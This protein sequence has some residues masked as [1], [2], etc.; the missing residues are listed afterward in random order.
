MLR[1]LDKE[2]G[3]ALGGVLVFFPGLA[4]SRVTDSLGVV[5]LP[6]GIRDSVRVITTHVGYSAVD[7]VVTA[8]A[9]GTTLDL[10]L[11]RSAIALAPLTVKAERAG[12]NSRELA[13]QMFEREVAIGA[14]G[15][16]RAEVQAVPA[17]AETDVFR[18][19]RSVPGVT[20][21]NDFGA[22]MFVRGGDADQVAVLLDGAP[23]FGPYHMFGVFGVFNSDAI[24]STE[25]YKGSIPARY[26]GSLSGVVSARQGT[27]V[28]GGMSF[29]G[30]LSVLGLRGAMNGA[31][32]WAHGRWLVAGRKATVD[33]AQLSVPFS[34]HDV[35]AAV[36][37]YPSE[38]HRLGISLLASN[39]D[40]S[41]DFLGFGKS[42]SS[43][44]ANLVS[45][46]TWSWVRGNR[47]S[48]DVSAYFSR[49]EGNLATGQEPSALITTNRIRA[50]GVRAQI[51][52]RGDVTGIRSGLVLEGGPVSLLGTG[53]G[54]YM[55]G[56]G[57]G[58]FLHAS[59]F[60]E[61]EHWIGALRL[62]PGIRAGT[63]RS[64][65]PRDDQF[66]IL[67]DV[68]GRLPY[69]GRADFSAR[70]AFRWGDWAIVPFLSV[71]NITGRANV[72]T[73]RPV[74]H[75]TRKGDYLVAERQLPLFPFVG[76]DFRFCTMHSTTGFSRFVLVV[77]TI[78]ASACDIVV[79]TVPPG[80]D[81]RLVVVAAL[82]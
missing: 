74:T 3:V 82:N 19:L 6:A 22:E 30:G 75:S 27:G 58:T 55:E 77:G 29:S 69:H 21:I 37:L 15:M 40:F 20:S 59:A 33:V 73:Y 4:E 56:D 17:V 16:T 47:I 50:Q 23:V 81:D 10:L 42:L 32:P 49:Y 26:G 76:V 45:S 65:G 8:P 28:A 18:S 39:D 48:S 53:T 25:F 9:S 5:P 72:L 67:S 12:V 62:A 57:S 80:L 64:L 79:P 41:W 66:A 68:Q 61:L 71:P 63:E 70:Y 51:T 52:V 60:A 11:V 44:W 36:H 35:N 24:E 43:D 38:E 13:R 7:T 2:S 34:F 14:V 1:V 54:A 31:L 46:V 78:A